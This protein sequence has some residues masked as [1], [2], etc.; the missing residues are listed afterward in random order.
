VLVST[1]L[2]H[3]LRLPS[4]LMPEGAVIE[5]RQVRP[6]KEGSDEKPEE[7]KFALKAP[8]AVCAPDHDFFTALDPPFS[9]SLCV[10]I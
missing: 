5:I 8:A 2:A 7:L 3:K 9:L 4:P 6:V 10:P 1:D